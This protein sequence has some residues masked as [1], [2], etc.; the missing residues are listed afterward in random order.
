MKRIIGTT[1]VLVMLATMG[2]AGNA[3]AS[4]CSNA[5][6][7]ALLEEGLTREQINRV[8]LKAAMKEEG[9]TDEQIDRIILK[10][11]SMPAVSSSAAPISA[12][13][14]VPQKAD[15]PV[16]VPAEAPQVKKEISPEFSPEKI[17]IDI[18]GECVG[19]ILGWCFE[20]GEYREIEV[21]ETS[22]D[23]NRAKVIFHVQTIREH[24][25]KLIAE[26][27]KV[28]GKWEMKDVES[29]DFD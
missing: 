21:L 4:D 24:S 6:V 25:G 17:D 14:P 9:L 3:Y 23:G 26:Y 8:C 16:V 2:I 10:T 19:G 1:A 18:V 28:A 12:S 11:E 22:I 5:M 7:E 29:I 20:K 13:D 15:T 27:R